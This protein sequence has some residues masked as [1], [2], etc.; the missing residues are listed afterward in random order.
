MRPRC[1]NIS[2]DGQPLTALSRL[3]PPT[4]V[5]FYVGQNVEAV[6]RDFANSAELVSLEDDLAAE[7][8]CVLG[9]RVQPDGFI[10]PWRR[11]FGEAWT[12]APVSKP[13]LSRVHASQWPDVVD[14]DVAELPGEEYVA[15]AGAGVFHTLPPRKSSEVAMG[16]EAPLGTGRAGLNI[17]LNEAKAGAFPANLPE[18]GEVLG[19]LPE[20]PVRTGWS[21]L[22]YIQPA[23]YTS[24]EATIYSR[25]A[26]GTSLSRESP[27]PR[28]NSSLPGRCLTRPRADPP[29]HT[30]PH[31]NC[32]R[33]E[34]V[35][36]H[37]K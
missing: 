5:C 16:P 19:E 37:P 36:S 13:S 28:R 18:D 4:A 22:S 26:Y 10:P 9:R 12:P 15:V 2:M 17:H 27:P 8:R 14:F 33:R 3:F 21:S 32:L 30:H 23:G 6:I 25:G 31:P 11:M 7:A 20:E 24:A 29:P 34:H 1:F 35:S